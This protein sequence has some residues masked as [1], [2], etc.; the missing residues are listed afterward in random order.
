MK[1]RLRHD[2][3]ETVFRKASNMTDFTRFQA[4]ET[5]L[6]ET[7]GRALYAHVERPA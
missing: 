7:H 2:V 6:R 1:R 4:T 3:T 5:A